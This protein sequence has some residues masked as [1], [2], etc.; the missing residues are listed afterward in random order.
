MKIRLATEADVHGIAAVVQAMPEL[1]S[2][3]STSLQRITKTIA[4]NL[5]QIA[6]SSNSSAYVA[7]DSTGLIAGYC[8]VHWVPFI[9]LSDGEAYVTELFVRPTDSGQETGS[10]L[11]DNVVAEARNRGCAR[12]SLLNARDGQSY[13][14]EFYKKRG[15]VERDGMVNFILP[16]K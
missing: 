7:E 9:F 14:R 1:S 15:W 5:G 6:L 2:T 13:R 12:V 16:L 10:K 11:L 4:E 3:V 8:A